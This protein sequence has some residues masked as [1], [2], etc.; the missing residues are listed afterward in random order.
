MPEVK[1]KGG[2]E[3]HI[4]INGKFIDFKDGKAQ[5][6]EEDVEAIKKLNNSDYKVIK[7]KKEP[8]K[9]EE[10]T[11]EEE[12]V[13]EGTEDKNPDDKPD[14]KAKKGTNKKG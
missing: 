2:K 13:E 7:D 9:N 4:F 1:F 5:V 10:S 8:I 3:K 6:T 11:E 12:P 14:K